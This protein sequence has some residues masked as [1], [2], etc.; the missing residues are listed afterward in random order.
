MGF[1]PYARTVRTKACTFLFLP[2][3]SPK[4]CTLGRFWGF[5]LSQKDHKAGTFLSKFPSSKP[6]LAH[7][8][9]YNLEFCLS[10][11]GPFGHC[12]SYLWL[13]V[14]NHL[15]TQW[16][17]TTIISLLIILWV[18][19]SGRAE[20]NSLSLLHVGLAGLTQLHS[21]VG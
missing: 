16:L 6:H 12:F 1:L 8:R 9:G 13:C 7:L 3:F 15:R 5:I 4:S 18:R 21:A 14:P 2:V 17:K 20:W 10:S 11:P 19:N